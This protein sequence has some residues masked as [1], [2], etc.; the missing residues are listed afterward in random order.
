VQ[1]YFLADVAV[2]FSVSVILQVGVEIRK[3]LQL[4]RLSEV[5]EDV[6]KEVSRCYSSLSE[7]S[8]CY[9]KLQKKIKGKF[10]HIFI[11]SLYLNTGHRNRII[12]F[13]SIFT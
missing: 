10:C 4:I 2:Y 7:F 11:L 12:I 3:E 9:G 6:S 13:I 8:C 1:Y 5:T